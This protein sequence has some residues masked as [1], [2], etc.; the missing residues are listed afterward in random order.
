[1]LAILNYC[2]ALLF[3]LLHYW[4]ESGRKFVGSHLCKWRQVNQRIRPEL[5]LV[6]LTAA[7]CKTWSCFVDV[8]FEEM[9][10]VTRRLDVFPSLTFTHIADVTRISRRYFT[11]KYACVKHWRFQKLCGHLPESAA[12]WGLKLVHIVDLNWTGY[13][14]SPVSS[15][16]TRLKATSCASDSGGWRGR[17]DIRPGRHFAT[18]AFQNRHS[19]NSQGEFTA[20]ARVHAGIWMLWCTY[21]NVKNYDKNNIEYECYALVILHSPFLFEE[22]Y[23]DVL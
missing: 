9:S 13:Q 7:I 19:N 17:G 12:A 14:F 11:F 5:I 10:R 15:M 1:M 3:G 23:L 2:N 16:W 4:T 21:W 18:A 8:V 22:L 6:P 20:V